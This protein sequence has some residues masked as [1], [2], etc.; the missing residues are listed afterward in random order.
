MQ[1]TLESHHSQGLRK[2]ALPFSETLAQSIANIAPTATPA[3]NL[4]FVFAASL[5]GTWFTYLVATIGL[6]LIS[7]CISQFAK[8]SATPGSLYA[9]VSEGLGPGAGF[10]VG[11]ALILAYLTTGIAVIAGVGVYANDLLKAS[12]IP[13]SPYIVYGACALGVFLIAYKDVS[14]SARVMLAIEGASVTFIFIVALLAMSHKGFDASQLH[15]EGLTGNGLRTGLVLAIFSFVGFESATA[16]GGEAQNPLKNVPRSVYLSTAISG[17]FFVIMSLVMVSAFRGGAYPEAPLL[18]LG[19]VTGIPALGIICSLFA[20]VSLFACALASLTA[21]SRIVLAMGRDRLL[22]VSMGATHAKNETPH[23]ASGAGALLMFLVPSI[24]NI[25]GVPIGDVYGLNGTIATYGFLVA[26]ICIAVAAV[27]FLAKIKQSS[28]L[29]T[30]AAVVGTGMMGVAVYGSVIPYQE[31][32]YGWLPIVFAIYMTVGAVCW[33][34]SRPGV[35]AAA[36]DKAS[37]LVRE[38]ELETA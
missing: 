31:A 10:A 14:V 20:M 24:M 36:A 8:R 29:I 30:T 32:P 25:R 1:N 34:L 7:V 11:W 17:T 19:A 4:G 33:M 37:R 38:S 28:P 27:V 15:L 16:M 35:K 12:G 26:Y 18:G 23:M 22:H 6:L 9:Y 2:D 5:G 13:I 3:V 21:V